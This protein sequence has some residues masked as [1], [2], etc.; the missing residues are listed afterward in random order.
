METESEKRT[1]IVTD[2]QTQSSEVSMLRT[3]E[4]QLVRD[5]EEMKEA[6]SS[7]EEELH[8]LKTQ[9]SV[10]DVQMRELQDTLE[11]EQYFSVS[12]FFYIYIYCSW[13]IMYVD[14]LLKGI[15]V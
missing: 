13:K 7:L 15:I 2:L 10:D 6:R 12:F 9:K 4:K 1:A 14:K 8:K 5:L 11:A 3:R